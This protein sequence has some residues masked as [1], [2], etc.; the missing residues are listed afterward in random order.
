M[1]QARLVQA[2]IIKAQGIDRGRLA[3]GVPIRHFV[4]SGDRLK[5]AP[6]QAAGGKGLFTKELDSALFSGAARLA[7]HSMKDVPA[8]LPDGLVLVCALEREDPRDVLLTAQGSGKLAD[9]P[10]SARLG[11]ASL[12]RAAQALSAR[13]DLEIVLLRGNVE[14]RI[15]KLKQGLAAATF[16]ARAGLRRLG[17]PEAG[18]E[19]V[20]IDEFLPAAGQGVIGLV[21]RADDA[22]AIEIASL[23]N[24][25]PSAVA[26]AAERAVMRALDASCRT[27]VAAYALI[28][29]EE[30]WLRA[31]ALTPDGARR[32]RREGRTPLGANAMET[33]DKLGLRV[34]AQLRADGG[35][36]LEKLLVSS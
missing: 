6:L 17:W 35:D 31:E 20:N 27:P 24:H 22:E 21:A 16:L 36:V 9:L 28:Q 13:P 29:N 7:V 33:A 10:P 3:E 34:G 4:T 18:Y 1:A 11:T 14:T 32:W 12:R 15:S 30:I 25:F 23:L 5:D 26:L 19:P 2:L 8:V